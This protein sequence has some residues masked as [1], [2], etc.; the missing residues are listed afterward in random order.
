MKR[1]KQKTHVRP[2][3][4][5]QHRLGLFWSSTPLIHPPVVYSVEYNLY[6]YIK[7]T[8]SKKNKKKN[9]KKYSPRTQTTPDMSFGP[10]LVVSDSHLSPCNA[11]RRVKPVY[12]H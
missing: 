4:R 10:V 7:T 5:G 11:F 8:I 12:I 3:Q 6:T 9:E 2:K 1:R